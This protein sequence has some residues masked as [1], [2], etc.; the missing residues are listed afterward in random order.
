MPSVTRITRL[1][2]RNAM[3]SVTAAAKRRRYSSALAI[4]SRLGSAR[5]L[6]CSSRSAA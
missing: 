1:S 4:G 6:C 3:Y 5:F 2:R